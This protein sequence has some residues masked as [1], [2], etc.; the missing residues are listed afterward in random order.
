LIVISARSMGTLLEIA[1]RCV[2]GIEEVEMEEDEEVVVE[3]EGEP[4]WHQLLHRE[5]FKVLL[6][7]LVNLVR[8]CLILVLRIHLYP[9]VI[10]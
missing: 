3:V 7:M 2:M 4:S 6:F 8:F 1:L 5:D 10:V 9:V